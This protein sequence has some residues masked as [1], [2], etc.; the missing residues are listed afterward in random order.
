MSL[1]PHFSDSFTPLWPVLL[2][3]GAPNILWRVST[4]VACFLGRFLDDGRLGLVA[5]IVIFMI[6]PRAVFLR[7][8][9]HDLSSSIPH[10]FIH[11]T[12]CNKPKVRLLW[13]L[14]VWH[15]NVHLELTQNSQA[16]RFVVRWVSPKVTYGCFVCLL[17]DLHSPIRLFSWHQPVMRSCQRSAGQYTGYQ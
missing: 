4:N 7:P 2:R 12:L 6:A 13:S 15:E 10:L 8:K 14:D 17:P 9:R 11:Q 5:A 3:S 1:E 16:S